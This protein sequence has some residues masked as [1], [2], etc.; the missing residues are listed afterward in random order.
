MIDCYSAASITAIFH[1]L[2]VFAFYLIIFFL[3]KAFYLF[4]VCI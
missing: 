2:I 4:F 3:R 1:A